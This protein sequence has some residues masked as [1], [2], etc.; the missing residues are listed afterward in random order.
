MHR[1]SIIASRLGIPQIQIRRKLLLGPPR[2]RTDFFNG[3]DPTRTSASAIN[4]R[5][6]FARCLSMISAQTRSRLSRGRTAAHFP[7]RALEPPVAQ[8]IMRGCV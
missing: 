6:A 2:S 3:I 5:R 7:D 4:R 1:V 8:R